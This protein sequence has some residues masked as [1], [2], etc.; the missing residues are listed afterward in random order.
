[1]RSVVSMIKFITIFAKELHVPV[2]EKVLVVQVLE[3]L[4]V[5]VLQVQVIQGV[6][7]SSFAFWTL[8][9]IDLF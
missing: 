6:S 4:G 1:M 2:L 8:I 7:I 3:E 5:V 9:F